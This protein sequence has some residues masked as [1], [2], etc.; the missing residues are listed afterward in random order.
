MK[1]DRIRDLVSLDVEQPI[2]DHFYMVAPLVVVGTKEGNGYDLAP[3]HQA[4]PLGHG[5][6]FGFMC[7]PRH[8]TW[9]NI[10]REGAFTVSFP[11]PDQ[12]TLASLSASPRCGEA[13]NRKP[14]ISGLPTVRAP[15]VDAPFLKNSY[16]FLECDLDRIVE[17]F[18]DFGLIVGV[19]AGAYVDPGSLKVSEGDDSKMIRD[20]PL[21]AYL[22]H[23]RFAEIDEAYVFPF[24]KDF[25]I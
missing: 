2:W 16:L 22:A 15:N 6:Y 13:G 21:L 3:K 12:V 20:N 1:L 9:Q 8:S 19:I 7:T 10:K 23:G 5:R 17:G 4:M 24:P 14:V 18:E 25:R 11:R